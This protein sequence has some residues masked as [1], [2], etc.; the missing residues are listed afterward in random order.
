[1]GFFCGLI[2]FKPRF[3]KI[4][5]EV[6]KMSAKL[7]VFFLI[8]MPKSYGFPPIFFNRQLEDI[9]EKQQSSNNNKLQEQLTKDP[10]LNSK[11]QT[12]NNH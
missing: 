8:I 9:R 2:P 3:Y 11:L 7:L 10:Q 6:S 1:M 12:I 5:I 4:M